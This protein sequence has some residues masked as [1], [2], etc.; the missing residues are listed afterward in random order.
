MTEIPDLTKLILEGYGIEDLVGYRGGTDETESTVRDPQGLLR[1][2]EVGS[3]LEMIKS[4]IS[5][6]TDIYLRGDISKEAYRHAVVSS[7]HIYLD[8][9]VGIN[10]GD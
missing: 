9:V 7:F 5:D 2:L 6:L 10:R 3:K 8:Y 4:S 1:L